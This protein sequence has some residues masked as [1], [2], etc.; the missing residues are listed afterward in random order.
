[1][2]KHGITNRVENDLNKQ[3]MAFFA[4]S[5]AYPEIWFLTFLSRWLVSYDSSFFTSDFREGKRHAQNG[6]HRLVNC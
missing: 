3:T 4:R 2:H 5:E 1:M 6:K